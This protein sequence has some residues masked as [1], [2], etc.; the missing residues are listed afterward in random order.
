[1]RGMRST[2]PRRRHENMDRGARMAGEH[3]AALN[4]RPTGTPGAGASANRRASAPPA[5]WIVPHAAAK[6]G[7]DSFR[8]S[9]PASDTVAPG[10]QNV[11]NALPCAIRKR[12][13]VPAL[14]LA[15]A[16]LVASC[17]GAGQTDGP[18]SLTHASS[19]HAGTQPPVSGVPGHAG[20]PSS[21]R[22]TPVSAPAVPAATGTGTGGQSVSLRP[23]NNVQ[24]DDLLDRWGRRNLEA[25]SGQLLQVTESE[26]DVAGFQALLEAA[27]RRGAESPAPGLQD[28]DAVTALGQRLGVHYGRWSGGAADTLSI[29]FDLRY[30]PADMRSDGSFRAALERAGKM[31]SRRLGDTWQEWERSAGESKGRLI[32]SGGAD[33]RNVLVG[34]YGETSTGLVIYVTGVD[35]PG[36]LAGV[37]GTRSVRPGDAWEPHTGAIAFDRDFVAEAGEADLFRTMVHEVGHVL[38]SWSGGRD[39]QRYAS[40][41]D[42]GSGTWTGP[43]VVRV[44]GRSAP[45]QD[46]DDTTG[47]HYGERS[48]DARNFDFGHSGICTSIMA[49]CSN[50]AGIHGLEPAEVDFAFLRDLGLTTT[51]RSQRPETYGLAGWMDHS[52]F[53][54]SVSREFDVSLAYPQSRYF[55]NGARWQDLSTTDILWAEAAALGSPSSGSL[56]G[57]Y[58]LRGTVR[59]SGG[60][61]GTAVDYRGLPPVYGDANLSIGLEDM[62]GKASFTSLRTSYGG[63][64]DVFGEGSLH[65]PIAVEDNGIRGS[66]PGATL[67]AGFYG[68]RHRE[69]AGTLD[70]SRAGLLAS[71]G[72]VHDQ[73]PAYPDVIA[74]ADHIRGLMLQSGVGEA[75][76][77]WYR[78]RCGAGAD[79]EGR[80]EWWEPGNQWFDVG[81]AGDESPRERVL[82]WT[83]GWGDWISEDMFADRGDISISRRYAGGGD[84]GTGR[85]DRDG[86]Y[87]TM[88]HAAF[89][90]GF[91]RY[92]NWLQADG[93][94]WDFAVVGAGFQGEIS[95]TRPSGRATWDG[96]MLGFQQ[97]VAPGEDPYVE[98]SATVSLSL[99]RNLVDIGFSDVHSMDRM[100]SLADFGF[101]RI[102][103]ASDGTFDGFDGGPVEG[104]F[105]G[106][107]HEEAAGMFHH[108]ANSTIGSFGAVRRDGTVG[109]T[110]MEDGN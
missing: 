32:E 54:L 35:L 10:L 44:H 62:T 58:P 4:G 101:D 69:V 78:Y 107:A 81:A 104:A 92:V 93:S 5:I 59:W 79:C 9:R 37:A 36:D 18:R 88:K 52:A 77:G 49:Y 75:V 30:A 57:S 96:R 89:G 46:R 45:F 60:L 22:S 76:D 103:L 15:S 61:L 11:G 6:G 91:Y 83:A 26:A 73:R 56:A 51:P 16:I 1:M 71:F 13:A 63:T 98:G 87:G 66:T 82:G 31:W 20:P 29:E 55:A 108:N 7:V 99:S 17:V 53:T 40:F 68:P 67:A 19:G 39:M 106:P 41:T 43:N 42:F 85:H 24:A 70:D 94:V 90:T 25:V 74:E 27:Q 23:R 33:G 3:G 38:G 8:G 86:Y 12:L 105:F 110:S 84:G 21:V 28:G 48:P 64:G 102:P 72:A 95:G 47:W 109:R 97:G 34:P 2:A 65:Y 100:R 80:F 14:M 50:T